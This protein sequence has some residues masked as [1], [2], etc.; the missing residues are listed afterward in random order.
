[1]SLGDKI[2]YE[3]ALAIT[4]S[5]DSA[6]QKLSEDKQQ[7]AETRAKNLTQKTSRYGPYVSAGDPYDWCKGA[8]ATIL[9]EPQGCEGDC[10]IPLDYWGDGMTVAYNAS[11]LLSDCYIGFVNAAVAVVHRASEF[12]ERE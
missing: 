6:G 5:S 9:M 12:D 3:V 8:L 2:A 1:M 7:D 4:R 11:E 10:V